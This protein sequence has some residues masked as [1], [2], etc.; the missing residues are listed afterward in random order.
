MPVI[1]ISIVAV[2]AYL[3]SL[4]FILPSLLRKEQN[5]YRGLALLFA[6]VALVTHAISLKFLIFRPHSGQNLSL[7][8]LGAVVSLMVCVIMTIVASRGRAW[9]LLPIVYCFSIVNL[10]IAALMPGEL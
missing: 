3:L 1:S 10:I 2:C 5:G 4:V 8:N 6:V 9:F 7:T